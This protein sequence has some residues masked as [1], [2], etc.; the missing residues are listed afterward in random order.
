MDA[1]ETN[2]CFGSTSSMSSDAC[3]CVFVPFLIIKITTVKYFPLRKVEI[4][5]NVTI[6][7]CVVQKR[8]TL[9]IQLLLMLLV[10][11]GQ[12]L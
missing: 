8:H 2:A 11:R 1:R 9:A 12:E 6:I 4:G 3:L 5:S 7:T 10:Q